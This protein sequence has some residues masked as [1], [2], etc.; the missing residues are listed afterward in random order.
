MRLGAIFIFA[1]ILPALPAAS[2][3]V[4]MRVASESEIREHLSESSKNAV[5]RA[6]GYNYQSGKS[7]G[8]KIDNGKICLRFKDGQKDCA[9]VETDGT[10][11]QLVTKDGTRSDL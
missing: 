8:Y 10:R 5:K 1:A 3:D 2:A 7:F 4:K 6:D 9:N 11:F